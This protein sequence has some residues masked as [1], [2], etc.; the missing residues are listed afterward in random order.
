MN[1][2]DPVLHAAWGASWRALTARAWYD[3]LHAG[4]LPPQGLRLNWP[5]LRL[6]EA[7]EPSL[8]VSDFRTLTVY[9]SHTG[10]PVREAVW[11]RLDDLTQLRVE[12]DYSR[13]TALIDPTIGVRDGAVP[14][15][16]LDALI[17]E[18]GALTV[19]LTW[20]GIDSVCSAGGSCG[21][22]FFDRARDPATLR[23][24]WSHQLPPGREPVVEWHGR[25][26]GLLAGCLPAT[27]NRVAAQ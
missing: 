17:A 15:G 14:A 3:L 9:D 19:P 6:W 8:G 4:E 27:G 10:A 25:A 16:A 5:R 13:L 1:E 18:A 22:E 12:V 11:R 7:W 26:W 21:F 2:F 23:L 24:A 20:A